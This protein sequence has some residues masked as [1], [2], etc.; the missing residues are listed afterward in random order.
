[1]KTKILIAIR[2]EPREGC[3]LVYSEKEGWKAL[4]KDEFLLPIARKLGEAEE[5]AKALGERLAKSEEEIAS[6]KAS[7][8]KL[9]KAIGGRK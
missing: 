8:N 9:A 6:L 4:P 1:M 7:L 3:I 5:R 2:G